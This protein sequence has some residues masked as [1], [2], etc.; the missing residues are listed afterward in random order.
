MSPVESPP[1]SARLRRRSVPDALQNTYE[2]WFL[3]MQAT[4]E[5]GPVL[6]LKLLAARSPSDV[7]AA[8]QEWATRLS[9]TTAEDYSPLIGD[10]R[11]MGE[12]KPASYLAKT[13]DE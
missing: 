7:L 6:G 9:T 12:L 2:L 5:S 4:A 8:W 11:K 13:A 10:G 3:R 1:L